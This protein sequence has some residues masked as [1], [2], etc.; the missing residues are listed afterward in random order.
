MTD[1][2]DMVR[3]VAEQLGELR[4]SV[5]F[6]GGAVVPLYVDLV[7]PG[8]VRA[9]LDVDIVVEAVSRLE[10]Y[11]VEEQLRDLRWSQPLLEGGPI[12]RWRTPDGVTVDVMPIDESVLGFSNPWYAS[13]L[14]AAL[15]VKVGTDLEIQVFAPPVFVATKIE[16]FYGRGRAD[17]YASHDLEDILTVIEGRSRLVDEVQASS[18]DV[19]AFIADWA[20]R[21]RGLAA[22][23][24]IVEGHLSREA[25]RSGFRDVVI[26]RIESLSDLTH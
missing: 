15:T 12:C 9:T 17:W 20:R 2:Q 22:W 18:P 8:D 25:L 7:R 11:R 6:T 13:G 24:D 26:G 10:Y 5:V 1:S 4:S 21:L 19:R 23:H 16:A 3:R 14:S